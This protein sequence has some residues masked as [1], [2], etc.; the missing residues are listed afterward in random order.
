MKKDA[1]IGL[2]EFVVESSPSNFFGSGVVL[3]RLFKFSAEFLVVDVIRIFLNKITKPFLR[4]Y[5]GV[6]NSTWEIVE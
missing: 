3:V 4:S 2:K 6:F 1:H 5:C